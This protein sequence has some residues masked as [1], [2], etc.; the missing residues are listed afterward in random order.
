VLIDWAL[1]NRLI[2]QLTP[3]R[4]HSPPLTLCSAA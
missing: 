2:V 4:L 3:P 1:Q